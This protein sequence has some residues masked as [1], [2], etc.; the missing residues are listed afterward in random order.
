[1][2]EQDSD[3]CLGRARVGWDDAVRAQ[4]QQRVGQNPNLV[5]AARL[6]LSKQG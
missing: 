6:L 5:I 1:M 4:R 3:E 2:R